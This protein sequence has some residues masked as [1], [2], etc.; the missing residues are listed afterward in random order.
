MPKFIYTILITIGILAFLLGII[1]KFTNPDNLWIRIFV[2]F[3]LF[4]ILS[5]LLPLLYI[6]IIFITYKLKKIRLPDFLE[7][8]KK[9]FKKNLKLTFFL[10][11]L[12]LIKVYEII[13]N[14]IFI[15][16]LAFYLLLVIFY[17]IFKGKKSYKNKKFY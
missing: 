9:F 3:I 13:N 1:V 4:F 7:I 17:P 5:L 2:P 12:Y 10:S 15:L 6:V 11:L 14:L 8:Y 16:L